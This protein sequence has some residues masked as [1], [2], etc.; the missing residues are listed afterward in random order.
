MCKSVKERLDSLSSSEENIQEL[1]SIFNSVDGNALPLIRFYINEGAFVIRQRINPKGNDISLISELSYPPVLFCKEYGRANLPYHPM[2]YCCSFS[3]DGDAPLPR[4]LTLLET[5]EYIKDTEST[6]IERATCSRWDV[7]EK[8]DLLALPFSSSYKRTTKEIEQIK[9]EWEKERNNKN[10]NKEALELIE[11]MSNEI[12]KN[13]T[14]NKD[15]FKIANFVNYLL[16]INIRTKDSD[17]IIF[18]SV[19]AE[20]QG[21]NVVLKPEA[22]DS[23]LKFGGASLCYLVKNG[24]KAH[25]V[26]VNHSIGKNEDGTLIFEKNKEFDEEKYSSLTFIN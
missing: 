18:P 8:L 9:A 14:N 15:Y 24:K 10:I 23:K 7:I 26:I 21:F 12:A 17:G 11:Y 16:Y 22:A 13:I 20:G 19:A 4:F 3:S 5:S 1:Y 6:G 2:F 25:L